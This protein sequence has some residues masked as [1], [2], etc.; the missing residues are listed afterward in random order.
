MLKSS[1]LLL[2]IFLA[3]CSSVERDFGETSQVLEKAMPYLE[4]E[5]QSVSGSIYRDQPRSTK[6]GFRRNFGVGDILTVVLNE[7]TQAQ[8]SNGI[9]TVKEVANSPLSQL[10]AA[11][12]G[13]LPVAGEDKFTDTGIRIKRGLK[14]LDYL[15]QN[16]STKGVGTS[17]QAGSLNGALAV[18]V[19]KVLPNGTLFVEGKKDLLFSE[20]REEV[21]VSGLVKTDDVQPDDTILSSR[22]AQASIAYRGQGELAN[23][24]TSSWGTKVF[25]KIWP[26]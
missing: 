26:F 4:Y 18:I 23:V 19:T 2:T 1:T 14:A 13:G 10:K 12:G 11:F 7:S 9:N 20:G 21:Y 3:A 22:I 17:D 8:R 15:D 24:A 6:F 5:E 16:R 25:N